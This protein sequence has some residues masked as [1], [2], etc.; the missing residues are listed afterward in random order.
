M[1]SGVAVETPS[2][3]R[4]RELA[5]R[6]EETLDA[7]LPARTPV[8][9]VGVDS[10][11]VGDAAIDIATRAWLTRRGCELRLTVD[12]R[13]YEPGVVARRLGDDSALLLVGGGTVGDVWRTQ[14]ALRRRALADFPGRR[15]VQLP[16]TVHFQ[17]REAE[18]EARS[19]YE[20]CERLT[21]LARDAHSLEIARDRLGVRAA[22]SPDMAVLLVDDVARRL[23]SLDGRGRRPAPER[24]VLWLLRDD[25][26][27]AHTDARNLPGPPQGVPSC[28][29]P[30]P[31]RALAR[32]LRRAVRAT[33]RGGDAPRRRAAI[34]RD[35]E[36]EAR[37][38][39]ATGL[40]FVASARVV[41]T[42]RLHGVLLCLLASVP[43][44]AMPDR[45]GK[46]L[47]FLR[48]WLATTDVPWCE[49][50][51]EARA[52]AARLASAPA[53]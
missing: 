37:D 52:V 39:L 36:R 46:L 21:F 50:V 3:S 17:S 51:D 42:D 25:K 29:W 31:R 45:H 15:V 1:T 43:V 20:R 18:T 2:R 23:D 35:E 13:T 32:F 49:T 10:R 27:A 4:L 34:R 14:E 5:R 41:V 24:D 22:L 12:R 38:R 8:V 47:P 48:T 26:Q 9:L 40:A 19:L 6:L 11:N 16:Q 7:V 33:L 28:D 53:R 44:V 30:R